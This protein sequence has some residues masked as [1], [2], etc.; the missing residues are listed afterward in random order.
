MDRKQVTKTGIMHFLTKNGWLGNVDSISFLAAGEYNTNYI[1]K[2][3]KDFYVFRLNYGSQLGLDDQT[4]YEFRCLKLLEYTG[5]TP[6][7]FFY[8]PP[9]KNF[10][11]G[12]IL[13]EYIPGR[14]LDYRRDIP[15]AA[16]IFSKVHEV[17]PQGA[18]VDRPFILEDPIQA[19]AGE[20]LALLNK[21]P[22]DKSMS[23]YSPAYSLLS[24]IYEDLTLNAASNAIYFRDEEK[25]LVN[26]EVNSENFIIGE[27]PAGCHLVDWE[28]AVFS[29]RYMD[30]AHFMAK[31]TTLW[32][33][34][35]YLKDEERS[36]F[37]RSYYS[38]LTDKAGLTL[39][40]VMEKTKFIEKAV[41][42][43]AL[44][45]CYMAC[46]EYMNTGRPIK[47]LKTFKKIKEYLGGAEWF[48][49]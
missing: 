6:R 44:S 34:D 38:A 7:A 13:E 23:V 28:K 19:L 43:R 46:Y 47:N 26:T 2:S 8:E 41:L 22:A 5:V 21:Y 10:S 3:G 15:A 17:H 49:N 16:Y 33:T 4:G 11:R 30:L 20:S 31:T 29:C 18:A 45:W 25:C 35:Y 14:P 9:G 1:V 27:D 48:L 12:A 39:D 42:L 24:D 37:L 36:S 32:K 40:A